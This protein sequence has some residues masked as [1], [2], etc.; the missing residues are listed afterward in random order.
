MKCNSGYH[1][2]AVLLDKPSPSR[3]R[4]KQPVWY[5]ELNST[6]LVKLF[7]YFFLRA[8]L[9]INFLLCQQG[10]LTCMRYV[11]M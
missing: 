1:S 2:H 4:V 9:L 6:T 5:R 3:E 11:S 10:P 7:H 8:V